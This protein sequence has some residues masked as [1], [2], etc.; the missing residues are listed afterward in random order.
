M[1]FSF[2]INHSFFWSIILVA[3][4]IA[5]GYF[6]VLEFS[7]QSNRMMTTKSLPK[8]IQTLPFPAITICP[9]TKAQKTVLSFT[10]AYQTYHK[11]DSNASLSDR[12]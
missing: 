2:S 5:A 4:A 6:I 3:F 8:P 11:N 10:E 7:T 12:Q 9:E 1:K